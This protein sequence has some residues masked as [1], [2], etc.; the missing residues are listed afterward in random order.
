VY[1]FSAVFLPVFSGSGII[2]PV[3]F[4]KGGNMKRLAFFVLMVL[5]GSAVFAMSIQDVG[6]TLKKHKEDGYT[7]VKQDD[8]MSWEV[9]FT[10][11]NWTKPRTV[12]VMVGE[13]EIPDDDNLYFVTIFVRY[14]T[15][16][17]L[18]SKL[19][20]KLMEEN[21]LDTQW[22]SYS[23]YRNEEENTYD[24]NYDIKI[25]LDSL[26]V[27]ELISAV[28]WTATVEEN[29]LPEI[30]ELVKFQTEK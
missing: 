28:G 19:L 30:A 10:Q 11:E 14:G 2:L 12:Y 17:R 13:I 21:S 27:D 26:E 3:N 9:Q 24:L 8:E 5:S 4:Q 16:P 23:V 7:F 15:F 25:K 6:K 20:L 22:G 29:P 1:L 18:P